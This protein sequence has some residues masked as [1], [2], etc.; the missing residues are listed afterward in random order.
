MAKVLR[1]WK[2]RAFSNYIIDAGKKMLAIE[3][4]K[5]TSIIPLRC[6]IGK[7]IFFEFSDMVTFPTN[8]SPKMKENLK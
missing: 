3:K 1:V 8:I 4:V 7:L 5:S 2:Q 6:L